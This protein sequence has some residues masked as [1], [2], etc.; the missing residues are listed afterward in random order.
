MEFGDHEMNASK[1]SDDLRALTQRLL[2]SLAAPA[3]A[4]FLADWPISPE[5]DATPARGS[6]ARGAVLPAALPALPDL[7]VLRWLPRIVTASHG[8]G[9]DYVAAVCKA[10]PAL[11]WHQ[12]YTASDLG[13][14]FMQNYGWAEI[15][16]PRSGTAGGLACGFLLL[17]PNTL[18][19]HHRHPAEEIYLSLSG[20]ADWQQGDAV[21][22]PRAPGVLIHH[23]SEEPHAMRTGDDPLLALYLWRGAGLAQPARLDQRGAA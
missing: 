10:A 13:A 2:E 17:G 5:S 20:L 8:F 1:A 14:A 18:Y 16:G 3:L 7:P 21:W 6:P 15:F 4:P 12:T 23:R 22:R 19:P 9:S 11:A